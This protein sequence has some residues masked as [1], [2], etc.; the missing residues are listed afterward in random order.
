[1]RRTNEKVLLKFGL[2]LQVEQMADPKDEKPLFKLMY[3]SSRFHGEWH[4]QETKNN[5]KILQTDVSQLRTS[6]LS[7]SPLV[8]SVSLRRIRKCFKGYKSC[9]IRA[10]DT[11]YSKATGV[12]H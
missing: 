4:T 1:M 5:G 7:K 6:A 10:Q 11:N 8:W 2:E 3:I 9:G 12:F